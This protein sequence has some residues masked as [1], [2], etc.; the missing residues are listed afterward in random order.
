MK[1]HEHACQQGFPHR[2][3]VLGRFKSR[4]SPQQ[5]L[6]CNNS[7]FCSFPVGQRWGVSGSTPRFWTSRVKGQ[8]PSITVPCPPATGASVV[9]LP[10]SLPAVPLT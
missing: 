8:D 7:V 10:D 6:R 4:H 2:W 3:G 5:S 1:A 9:V